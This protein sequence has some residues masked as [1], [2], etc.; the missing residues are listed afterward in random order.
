VSRFSFNELDTKWFYKYSSKFINNLFQL[1][2]YPRTLYR[3]TGKY[4]YD[5]KKE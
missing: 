3:G 5:Y 4:N 2:N 1:P